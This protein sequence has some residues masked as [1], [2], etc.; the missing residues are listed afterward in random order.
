MT[1]THRHRLGATLLLAAVILL[2]SPGPALAAAVP[3]CV[4]AQRLTDAGAPSAAMESITELRK[5]DP[6]TAG[7]TPLCAEEYAAAVERQARD[8]LDATTTP[9]QDADAAWS[10]L[11]E[12][13]LDP[14]LV[15]VAVVLGWLALVLV[16]AR[17]LLG[18]LGNHL[19]DPVATGCWLRRTCRWV[20]YAAL[21]GG[22]LSLVGL[23]EAVD[24]D[25]G[26]VWS[27][28]SADLGTDVGLV[29]VLVVTVVILAL[30]WRRAAARDD[31]ATS[32]GAAVALTASV[33]IVAVV[34][35]VRSL[36]VSWQDPLTPALGTAILLGVAAA[37]LLAV[38]WGSSARLTITAAGEGA[39]LP[40]HLR[41]LIGR[42][43]P[44]TP[45]GIEVPLGTDADVLEDVGIVETSSTPWIAALGRAVR[46]LRPPTPWRLVVT[47]GDDSLVVDLLR[48]HRRVDSQSFDRA[49]ELGFLRADS[50]D[51]GGTDSTDPADGLDLG[52]FPAALAVTRIAHAHGITQ[53]LSGATVARSVALHALAAQEPRGS[54]I[55]QALFAEAVD[56][57]PGNRLAL[58][59]YWHSLYREATSKADLSRYLDLLGSALGS[60]VVRREPGLR[61][62]LL[63]T[64]VAV[65]VNRASL[66]R[67]E[68]ASATGSARR[69]ASAALDAQLL[70]LAWDARHL[71]TATDDRSSGVDEEFRCR[72]QRSA[73]MLT[74]SVPACPEVGWRPPSGPLRAPEQYGPAL[75]YAAGCHLA[76]IAGRSALAVRHLAC[77]DVDPTLAA[78]R[79]LD[80]Q[81]AGLRSHQPKAGPD[82]PRTNS[83][84]SR[85][86]RPLPDDMLTVTP[87]RDH[88]P[89]LRSAGLSTIDRLSRV[90]LERLEGLGLAPATGVW[91]REVAVLARSARSWESLRP[92]HLAV[93]TEL[94][95]L[96]EIGVPPLWQGRTELVA[97]LDARL[98]GYVSSPATGALDAWLSER[99]TGRMVQQ[100]GSLTTALSS[101]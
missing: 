16:L 90:T 15:L 29:A 57:D 50:T 101:W 11:Q 37:V 88:A 54:S 52:V 69:F 83:Y 61:L 48:N 10:D 77:A 91:L 38:D 80:P 26:P 78:W 12:R 89:A 94:A 24:V 9:A 41:S 36:D 74:R 64:R 95:A 70:A 81:L 49:T 27:G 42:I 20:A 62:R 14:G 99:E 86:G 65:G 53:G 17:L 58:V 21:T 22:A 2:P 60:D 68:R 35:L 97:R 84:R 76:E 82:S 28:G 6:V 43:A 63:H 85:F 56:L 31:D 66:L 47:A 7:T 98:E 100:R 72:L 96:G 34:G 39:P 13:W 75:N 33:G 46:L 18:L 55:A 51:G 3:G 4:A 67:Q 19:T 1:S 44:S 45:G 40:E 73:Q 87:F 8:Q 71:T 59:G 23:P 30:G 32:A 25:A 93:A 5:A 92:W 79:E